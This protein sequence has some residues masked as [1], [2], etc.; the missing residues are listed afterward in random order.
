[1]Y[2]EIK[3]MI[4]NDPRTLDALLNFLTI[5]ISEYII[6]QVNELN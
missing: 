6:Y 1:M 5:Q 3:T 2:K 4:F